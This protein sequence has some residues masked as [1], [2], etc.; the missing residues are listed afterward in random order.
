M[1]PAYDGFLDDEYDPRCDDNWENAWGEQMGRHEAAA[2]AL[3]NQEFGFTRDDVVLL[4]DL[5]DHLNH[6]DWTSQEVRVQRLAARILALL[7][8]EAE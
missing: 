5:G 6:L 8:P 3:Y 2:R 7:P 1:K 4:C